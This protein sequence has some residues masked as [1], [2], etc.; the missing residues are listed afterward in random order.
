MGE[1]EKAEGKRAL[2]LACKQN[3]YI[4]KLLF[5]NKIICLYIVRSIFY[6]GRGLN[7]VTH[8]NTFGIGDYF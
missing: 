4:S 5:K 7:F 6:I 1:V 8:E 3:K 2:G